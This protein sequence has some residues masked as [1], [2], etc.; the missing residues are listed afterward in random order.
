MTKNL[1]PA[2]KERLLHVR[3]L[4]LPLT[5]LGL[6]CA[7]A[8]A[9]PAKTAAL[10]AEVN[11]HFTADGRPIHPK[12]IWEFSGWLSDADP[13]TLKL[14]LTNSLGSDE[15]YDPDVTTR[16]SDRGDAG[17]A[18][19]WV[20]GKFSDLEGYED[21]DYEHLGR[22]ADGTHVLF[23]S[24]NTGGTANFQHL[25]FVRAAAEPVGHTGRWRV[26]LET[27]GTSPV[28]D[29]SGARYTVLPDR[30]R[31]VYRDGHT[32]EARPW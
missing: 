9:P 14:D 26:A 13:I 20:H 4:P 2:T 22:L 29:R 3:L 7:A 17:R 11:A 5:L 15:Y 24:E 16:P 18:V 25:S 1:L 10:L 12:L 19:R 28:G 27:A 23:I 30:V 6:A 21:F 32:N 31:I 8:P